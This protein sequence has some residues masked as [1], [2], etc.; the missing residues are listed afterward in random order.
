MNTLSRIST[1]SGLKQRTS[2]Q[3]IVEFA[4]ALPILLLI[5]F[6]IIEFGRLLQAYL[7]IENSAR[8]G[9]RYAI[10]GAYDSQYC[11]EADAALGYTTEDL[12]DGKADCKI[13]ST[14]TDWEKKSEQLQDWARLP[15]IWDAAQAGSTGIFYQPDSSVNYL[16]FL[17]NVSDTFDATYLGVPTERG[18]FSVTVC[19]NRTG[20]AVDPNLY[21]YN[22]D[23]KDENLYPQPCRVGAKYMD[24]AGGPGDRVRIL[25]T[26][27]HPFITPFLSNIWNSVRISAQ[28]EGIVEKFRTSRVTG[29]SG[30]LALLPTWTLTPSITPTA[31][32]TPTPTHTNTPEATNTPTNT[33]TPTKTP[34]ATKT[35]TPSKTP[36]QTP[37][38][39]CG[40]LTVSSPIKLNDGSKYLEVT[41]TNTDQNYPIT[42]TKVT[43]GWDGDWHDEVDS[44]PNKYFDKYV[45]E[46]STTI[47]DPSNVLLTT[48]GFS[49]TVSQNINANSDGDFRLVFKEGFKYYHGS[50]FTLNFD[51]TVAGL[52]C[53]ANE[54]TGKNGPVIVPTMPPD[55]IAGNFSF[56]ANV[57]NPGGQVNQVRFMVYNSSNTLVHDWTESSVPYCFN[58]DG[59]STCYTLTPLVDVWSRGY[60]VANGT[61]TLQIEAS[62]KD[63]PSK[64]YTRIKRTFRITSDTPTP[65]FTPTKTFT[66]TITS[67][68]TITR[69]PTITLTPT[70]TLTP[71]KTPTKTDTPPATN[72]P[73]KTATKTSTPTKTATPEATNTPTITKTYTLA[74]TNTPTKTNTPAPSKTP[75][76]TPTPCLTPFEMGGCK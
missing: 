24:D 62:N 10:T 12:K 43:L 74:P 22:N 76:R 58:G 18:Y 57:T 15:S 9:V 26:F 50:D 23:P 5:L 55:P 73:T 61:Y 3:S 16:G 63:S 38:P 32:D 47:L 42:I 25:V 41:L 17:Q 34:T 39:A 72:T 40:K 1:Q 14:E 48:S 6:G 28:R 7:A 44:R 66:P 2:A 36:T 45:W 19:S 60:L 11:D 59:G 13:P 69:T 33:R 8:F 27:R 49:H 20:V 37:T 31:S 30:G 21:Y 52:T 54:V 46:G 4:I 51:Y 29:L 75:T 64:L 35:P 68:P 67:T 70:K 65:T 53:N 71:S 56:S